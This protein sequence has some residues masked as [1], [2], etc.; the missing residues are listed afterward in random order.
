MIMSPF[1]ANAT[2]EKSSGLKFSDNSDAL[3]YEHMIN[4]SEIPANNNNDNSFELSNLDIIAGTGF[5][6]TAGISIALLKKKSKAPPVDDNID[7]FELSD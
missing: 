5:A 2:I 3:I 6:A 4:L 7:F 1:N